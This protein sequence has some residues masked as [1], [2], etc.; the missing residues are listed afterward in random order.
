[1][2]GSQVNVSY[3]L[4]LNGNPI[5]SPI[6]GTGS[7]ITFGLQNQAG[8]YTV[9]ATGGSGFCSGTY[10]LTN[11]A[12]IILEQPPTAPTSI[13]GTT[14]ICAGQSSTLTLSGGSD[15]SGASS[16]SYTHLTLPTICSV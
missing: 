3:Q 8:T 6:A 5:G 7:N 2:S 1:M 9:Q 12:T 4:L 11:S 10:T 13:S 15:G 16:V 14:T